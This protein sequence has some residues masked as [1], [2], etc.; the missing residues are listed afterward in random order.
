MSILFLLLFQQ[1]A[2]GSGTRF[3]Q[4]EPIM[5]TRVSVAYKRSCMCHFRCCGGCV[6]MMYSRRI[7]APSTPITSGVNPLDQ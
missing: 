3:A 7:S 2:R 1:P 6:T 4:A 5:A